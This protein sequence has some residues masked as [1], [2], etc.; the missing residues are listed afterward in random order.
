MRAKRAV[1]GGDHMFTSDADFD[2]MIG[3]DVIVAKGVAVTLHGLVNGD[4]LVR[5]GATVR[6]GAMVGG[7]VINQGGTVLTIA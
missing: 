4:L 6:L 7:Q 2:G 3:G 5:S 1:I